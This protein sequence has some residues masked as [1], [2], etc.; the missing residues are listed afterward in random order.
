MLSVNNTDIIGY[1]Y[2]VC[3]VALCLV[4]SCDVIFFNIREMSTAPATQTLHSSSQVH[5]PANGKR[6]AEINTV[7]SRCSLTNKNLTLLIQL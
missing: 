6:I 1:T 7:V 5:L 3:V 2:I 4:P